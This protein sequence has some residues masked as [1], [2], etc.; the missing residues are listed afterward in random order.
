M[1]RL[2]RSSHPLAR[3]VG[4]AGAALL[5]FAPP[6]A[7]AATPL[8][9]S[10]RTVDF[11]PMDDGPKPPPPPPKP[12]LPY[13]PLKPENFRQ[14]PPANAKHDAETATGVAVEHSP[15]KTEK[16]PD[17]S[18]TSKYTDLKYSSVVDEGQSYNKRPNDEELLKH[19]QGHFDLSELEARKRNA[20][21]K[22]A[23]DKLE[24]TGS[25][26]QEA[27]ADLDKKL[28]EHTK[29]VNKGL[30]E[31]QEQYDNETDHSKNGAKQKEWNKKIDDGLKSTTPKSTQVKSTSSHSAHYDAATKQLRFTDD[32]FTG[33]LDEHGL[34]LPGDDALLGAEVLLPSFAL[35]GETVAGDPFFLAEGSLTMS[36][37][38][39]GTQYF[40]LDLPYL[41]YHD[42]MFVGV[43]PTMLGPQVGGSA[44]LGAMRAA[45]D[46]G[47]AF[48]LGLRIVPDT[49]FGALTQGF[50][51]SGTSS[52][53]NGFGSV[54]TAPEPASATLLGAGLTA[55]LTSVGVARRR[56]A[57]SRSRPE[58]GR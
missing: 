36:A 11:R 55:L 40:A 4:T 56:A 7:R 19:E 41:L 5:L 43:S 12:D 27:E 25:T 42:G 6:P 28:D 58:S 8:L 45:F 31:K 29:E 16:Q 37:V 39:G 3:A 20:D 15:P 49:D 53:T 30:N 44:V 52:F 57:A 47:D 54:T 1:L 34:P 18:Y 38:E 23:L 2:P 50:T 17:G 26:P 48:L 24:G 35:V 46:A 22:K 21:K 10:P 51:A 32:V 13:Q 33:L 14:P 9:A